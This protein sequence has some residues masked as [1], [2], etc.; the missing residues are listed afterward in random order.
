MKAKDFKLPKDLKGTQNLLRKLKAQKL[1]RI[2]K[3]FTEAKK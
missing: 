3:M 1:K 2:K